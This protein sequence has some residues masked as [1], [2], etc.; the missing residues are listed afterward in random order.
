MTSNHSGSL[1]DPG[2]KT[3]GKLLPVTCISAS[4]P[5]S[6]PWPVLTSTFCVTHAQAIEMVEPLPRWGK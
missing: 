4:P 1:Q 2:Q 6:W 3:P 5:S